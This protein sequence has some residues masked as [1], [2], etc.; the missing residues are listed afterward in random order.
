MIFF[1]FLGRFGGRK[2]TVENSRKDFR[3]NVTDL[4]FEIVF[5]LYCFGRFSG[6]FLRNL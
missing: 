5:E 2:D 3:G 1:W 4:F 6:M